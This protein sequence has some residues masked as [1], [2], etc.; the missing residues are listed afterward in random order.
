[1]PPKAAKGLFVEEEAPVTLSVVSQLL[2]QQKEFYKE[3]LQQQQENFK[4]CVQIMIES[5]NKR[6]D[7]VIRDLQGVK[8]SLE[9][10]QAS[11]DGMSKEQKAAVAEIKR[12]DIAIKKLEEDLAK[13]PSLDCME[14]LDYIENQIRRNNILVDGIPDEKGES[15][16][17]SERKVRAVIQK[18]LGLD[19]NNIEIERAHR[20]GTYKEGKRSLSSF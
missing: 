2:E 15:W 13:I 9:F 7:D 10:T 5:V 19:V 4:C 14:K 1:M 17:E 3:M 6:M 12:L 16:D 20:I 8:T 11:V 18:N